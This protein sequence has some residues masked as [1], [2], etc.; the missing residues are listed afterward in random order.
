MSEAEDTVKV[1]ITQ[2]ELDH[3]LDGLKPEADRATAEAA[4]RTRVLESRADIINELAKKDCPEHRR[5]V[6][7]A[8]LVES[9]E[10]LSDLDRRKQQQQDNAHAAHMAA[11][12][13]ASNEI[14]ARANTHAGSLNRATWVLSVATVVLAVATVV[15]IF[16]TATAGGG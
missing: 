1:R 3:V 8:L 7:L 16:V 10:S 9:R 11:L 13:K 6:L 5:Q 12:A 2:E 14:A 4:L 15:L